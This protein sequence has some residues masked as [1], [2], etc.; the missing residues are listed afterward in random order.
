M[1]NLHEHKKYEYEHK[2]CQLE[3]ILIQRLWSQGLLCC[4]LPPEAVLLEHHLPEAV[5]HRVRLAPLALRTRSAEASSLTN[6][7]HCS[8]SLICS[9]SFSQHVHFLFAY[10]HIH[11]L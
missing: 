1:V 4:L 7:E 8:S 6:C 10:C 9:H 3:M 11:I 2:L 5:E